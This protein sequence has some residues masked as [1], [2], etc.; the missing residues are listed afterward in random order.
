MIR[1]KREAAAGAG[2]DDM[3][4]HGQRNKEIERCDRYFSCLGVFYSRTKRPTQP[5]SYK[6]LA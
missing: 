4:A 5:E 1:G 6:R 3:K 2:K